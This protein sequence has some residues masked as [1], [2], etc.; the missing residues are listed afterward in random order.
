VIEGQVVYSAV[1]ESRRF[2]FDIEL[3]ERDDERLLD[4][5]RGILF[6]QAKPPGRPP[7]QTNEE[8]AV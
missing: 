7:D 3:C 8:D 4:N 6:G 1:E 5:F 2:R